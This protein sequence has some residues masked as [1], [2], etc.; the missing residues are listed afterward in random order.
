MAPTA[1]APLLFADVTKQTEHNVSDASPWEAEAERW[2][3]WARTPGHDVFPHYAPAF[4]DGIVPAPA[5]RMLEVGCGE[6]R[7]TRELLARGH[8]V[9]ALDVSPTLVRHAREA[10]ARAAYAC[11]DATALPFADASFDTVVAYNSLQTM[12]DETDMANAVREAARVLKP[13]GSL[14][15]CVAHPWTDV[16]VLAR[17]PDGRLAVSGSYFERRRVDETVTKDGL[18]MRFH[19]WT[20]TLQDYV[21]AL[22]AAGL[23]VELVHEPAP[24]VALGGD[25]STWQRLPLFLFMRA[26]K[27]VQP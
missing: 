5:G 1:A 25:L 21:D 10:D 20:Y 8:R 15:M 19:G 18:T 17:G 4:F 24:S 12:A 3:A 7:V 22:S 16:G 23:I 26:R 6:G 14:C 9:V 11:G 27:V 2:V 13:S